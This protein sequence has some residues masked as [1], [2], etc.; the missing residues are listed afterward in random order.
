MRHRSRRQRYAA[1]ATPHAP[2]G[3]C[4]A[5]PPRYA[6]ADWRV[7]SDAALA[8]QILL[9]CQ[10]NSFGS[11]RA[12]RWR[13]PWS[14]AARPRGC[15]A[16]ASTGERVA[17]RAQRAPRASGPPPAA[18]AT[19]EP[20]L[21]RA[22]VPTPQKRTAVSLREARTAWTA[23]MRPSR[24][25]S[26]R[27]TPSGATRGDAAAEVDDQRGQAVHHAARWLRRCAEAAVEAEEEAHDALAADDG[28]VRGGVLAAVAQ[29]AH[30]LG[31]QRFHRRAILQ[32]DRASRNALERGARARLQRRG[33]ARSAGGRTPP[34]RGGRGGGSP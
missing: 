7:S 19:R 25:M 22:S 23:V 4:M 14:A 26:R 21:A 17:P 29:A 31:E 1:P 20:T 34:W 2:S 24:S 32:I 10:S 28:A 9:A 11:P 3:R 8:K 13:A 33:S 18:A 27:M 30:V 16:A 6:T 12:R 15:A 5:P